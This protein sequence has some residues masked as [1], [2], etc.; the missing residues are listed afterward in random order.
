MIKINKKTAIAVVLACTPF[1]ACASGGDTT[2]NDVI[3]QVKGLTGGSLGLLFC[4][5][6]FVGVC[7]SM[8]GMGNM[9]LMFSTFGICLS[10]RYGPA[11][12]EKLFASGSTGDVNTITN[13]QSIDMALLAI[14][15]LL[16]VA[17]YKLYKQ[18][19][20]LQ[21]QVQLNLA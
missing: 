5:L 21:Q 2:F 9:K 16:V 13:L 4:L 6:S 7:A 8:V 20:H 12:I 15:P 17:G 3:S 19:Q 18:K 14:T 11:I 1:L 10:L